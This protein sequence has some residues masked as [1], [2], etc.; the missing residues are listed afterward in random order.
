MK[1]FLFFN[2]CRVKYDMSDDTEVFKGE[3]VGKALDG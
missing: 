1:M 2:L 3:D